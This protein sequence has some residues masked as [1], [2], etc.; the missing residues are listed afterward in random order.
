[1]SA[2]NMFRIERILKSTF[3]EDDIPRTYGD[4]KRQ[5][6]SSI[7]DGGA[8]D[9][10]LIKVQAPGA[11]N[12]MPHHRSSLDYLCHGTLVDHVLRASPGR[13]LL[14][15]DLPQLIDRRSLASDHSLSDLDASADSTLTDDRIRSSDRHDS[16]NTDSWILWSTVVL[17]VTKITEPGLERRGVVLANGL[18]VGDDISLSGDRCPFAGAVEEG[19]VDVGVGVDVIGLARFGVGV[20][21]E[22]D[23]AGLL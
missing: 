19:N 3:D 21:E 11:A 23:A 9:S 1:M 15:A 10:C 13:D 12:A 6:V 14:R 20:E 2:R 5:L 18:A 22:V 4:S 8:F 17:S 16:D 7:C